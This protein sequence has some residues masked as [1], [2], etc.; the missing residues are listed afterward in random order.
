M[1]HDYIEL[2]LHPST[3]DDVDAGRLGNLVLDRL[4]P[5]VVVIVRITDDLKCKPWAVNNVTN[6]N[7]IEAER[8]SHG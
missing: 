8:R 1:P 3:L 7:R 2:L 5:G 6:Y 4:T